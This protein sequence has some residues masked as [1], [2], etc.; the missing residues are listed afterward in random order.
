MTGC[1]DKRSCRLIVSLEKVSE[2]SNLIDGHF[3]RVTLKP[4]GHCITATSVAKLPGNMVPL[5]IRDGHF[6][7]DY[8]SVRTFF[9]CAD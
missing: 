6:T 2:N 1:H 9:Y 5:R 7:Y 3:P 8:G 4:I